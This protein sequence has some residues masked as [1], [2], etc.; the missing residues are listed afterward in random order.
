M[1]PVARSSPDAERVAD[2]AQLGFGRAA[3]GALHD[4]GVEPLGAPR[5][6]GVGLGAA[7]AV[8]DVQRRDAIAELAQRVVEARR[9]GAARD[10]AEH[11]AARLDQLVAADV[12]LDALEN[13]Q[14]VI[15]PRVARLSRRAAISRPSH[16]ATQSREQRT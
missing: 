1:W 4:L 13:A 14:A 3:R 15:Q 16:R 9:V 12:L 5:S 6:V 7:Q 2:V 11:G 8:V 10:E